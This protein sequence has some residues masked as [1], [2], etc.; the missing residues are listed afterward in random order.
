[1]RRASVVGQ[2]LENADL[3]TNFEAGLMD[4]A[5]RSFSGK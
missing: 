4:L 2:V 1:L 5:C 3:A